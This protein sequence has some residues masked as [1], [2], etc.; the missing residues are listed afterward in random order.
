MPGGGG[1]WGGVNQTP[2]RDRRAPGTRTQVGYG[3]VGVVVVGRRL[4]VVAQAVH[5]P[6]GKGREVVEL[7]CGIGGGQGEEGAREGP[8]ALGEEGGLVVEEF[9]ALEDVFHHEQGAPFGGFRPS[10]R[11]AILGRRLRL[12]LVLLGAA[13]VLQHRVAVE[14]W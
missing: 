1:V 14:R 7:L 3:R 4:A 12:L 5:E 10:R 13:L 6:R 2:A 8:E 9:E 11:P